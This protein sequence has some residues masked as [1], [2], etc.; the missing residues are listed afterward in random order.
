MECGTSGGQFV[1]G[2]SARRLD[3]RK[4]GGRGGGNRTRTRHVTGFHWHCLCRNRRRRGRK[5]IGDRDG[6]QEQ[7]GP[8]RGNRHRQL[9][10]DRTVCGA[11]A[12]AFKLFYRSPASLIVVRPGGNGFVVHGRSNR[13]DGL[14][15]R[16]IELV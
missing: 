15:R 13:S 6:P 7:N 14:W 9:H 4:I 16:T 10:S 12:G 3:E 2:F 1:A 5:R 8:V 11:A